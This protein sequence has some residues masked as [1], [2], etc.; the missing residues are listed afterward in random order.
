M[1]ATAAVQAPQAVPDFS[2]RSEQLI[3][4]SKFFESI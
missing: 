1:A 4:L 2:K 3:E